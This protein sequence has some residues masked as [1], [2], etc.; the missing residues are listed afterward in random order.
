M[1]PI[2]DRSSNRL[3]AISSAK[4]QLRSLGSS[5]TIHP[6]LGGIGLTLAFTTPFFGIAL[7]LDRDFLSSDSILTFAAT[8][9]LAQ[10][11]IWIYMLW[12]PGRGRLH[13]ERL[14]RAIRPTEGTAGEPDPLDTNAPW[15]WRAAFW[16]ALVIL[17]TPLFLLG[18]IHR[19]SWWL[20][21]IPHWA[22][23][24][25]FAVSAGDS[26]AMGRWRW[27]VLQ[28]NEL[29][30]VPL[31]PDRC[32]GL[33]F[34]GGYF[35]KMYLYVVFAALY[36]TVALL[37]VA[38]FADRHQ[39]GSTFIIWVAS[40]SIAAMF[41]GSVYYLLV[42]PTR[43]IQEAMR[44][45]RDRILLALARE[46]ERL[47]TSLPGL[48][49]AKTEHGTGQLGEVDDQVQRLRSL[50][51]SVQATYPISPFR[52]AWVRGFQASTV[53]A[54]LIGA[55]PVAIEIMKMR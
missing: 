25:A 45:P 35:G 13:R 41:I 27:N 29:R 54:V 14:I 38:V 32:G 47:Q 40:I 10:A 30:V 21:W 37:T 20:Y 8:A 44:K 42:R 4:S 36:L 28:K 7:T 52:L 1:Q 39:Q 49:S 11:P 16:G 53:I 5:L 22:C 51:Q 9:Y 55:A 23:L 33:S 34:V 48:I 2:I 50:Y 46:A 12:I 18:E 19:V 24:A 17:S 26:F 15:A 43:W 3:R 6:V 31:H